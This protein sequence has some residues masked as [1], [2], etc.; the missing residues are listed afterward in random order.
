MNHFQSQ[1]QNRPI[2]Q[3]ISKTYSYFPSFKCGTLGCYGNKIEMRWSFLHYKIPRAKR[4][5]KALRAG[6]AQLQQFYVA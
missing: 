2:F 3:C 5:A 4:A 6:E 1:Y